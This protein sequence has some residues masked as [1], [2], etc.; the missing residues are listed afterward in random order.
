MTFIQV[1]AGCDGGDGP[2]PASTP[3]ANIDVTGGNIVLN[4][5]TNPTASNISGPLSAPGEITGTSEIT[6][7]AT[8][9]NGP[10][11]YSAW[12]EIDGAHQ[13]AVNIGSSEDADSLC[14]D[15]QPS[16]AIPAFDSTQPCPHEADGTLQLNTATLPDGK[17]SLKLYVQDAAGSTTLAWAGT[18]QTDNSPIITTA[19][20][21]TGT[22]RVGSELTATH[23]TY[24]APPGAGTISSIS[25]RWLRCTDEQ[26]DHCSTI[27]NATNQ[28]YTPAAADTGYR[29]LYQETIS[30]TDGTTTANSAPTVP[31]TEPCQSTCPTNMTATGS[32]ASS[33]STTGTA[34]VTLSQALASQTH[35]TRSPWRIVLNVKPTRAHKHTRVIISATSR[36]DHSHHTESSYSY[37]PGHYTHAP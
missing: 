26:A 18:I 23:G 11:I 2:C 27:P 15:L 20:A 33:S 5:H 10:G 37:A 36:H 6:L 1:L 14:H 30:D 32:T 17:H 24:I 13:P 7:H 8:D 31:I 21:I 22:A 34:S 19:P 29:L 28:T 4:D 25:G 12:L 16:A 9:Q 3:I 35:R